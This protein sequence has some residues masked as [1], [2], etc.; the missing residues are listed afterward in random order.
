[1]IHLLKINES[2]NKITDAI[3][4]FRKIK[5]IKID[6]SQENFIAFYLDTKNS[7]IDSEIVFIGGLD[8]ALIDIKTLFRK[9][10]LKNSAKI[11]VAHNHPSNELTPSYED[12]E[13]FEKL[14]EAG[15]I[16]GL[17]VLD[18]IIFNEREFYSQITK[19]K[20]N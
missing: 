13:V 10:L 11:I 6:Y 5:E 8:S 7:V 3:D 19:W 20:I 1:M 12:K 17:N 9:A 14:K 18:S 2:K 4:L 15:E 16:I